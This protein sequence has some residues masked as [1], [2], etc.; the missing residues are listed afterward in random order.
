MQCMHYFIMITMHLEEIIGSI[1]MF[2]RCLTL[3]SAFLII[4]VVLIPFILI[5]YDCN[6]MGVILKSQK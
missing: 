4:L 1:D 2:N 3:R 5:I 6:N